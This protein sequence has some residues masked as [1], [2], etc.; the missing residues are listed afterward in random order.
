[1][2]RSLTSLNIAAF[3]TTLAAALALA[4][5]ATV[6]WTATPAAA[7]LFHGGGGFHGGGFGGGGFHPQMGFG[8]FH[9]QMGFGF[10]HPFDHRFVFVGGF[11][12]GFHDRFHFGRLQRDSDHRFGIGGFTV[13]P[14]YAYDAPTRAGV[15]IPASGSAGEYLG[16]YTGPNGDGC[17]AVHELAYN[18]AGLYIG[19]QIIRACP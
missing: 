3:R 18:S 2:L 14:G 19:E 5:A 8:G 16:S 1:M 6:A 4:L 13:F 15:T 11:H 7:G 9:P 17:G 12:H 10:R